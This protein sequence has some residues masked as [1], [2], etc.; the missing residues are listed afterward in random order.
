[1]QG[2]KHVLAPHDPGPGRFSLPQS[3]IISVSAPVIQASVVLGRE[4]C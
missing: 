4:Q 3:S 1:M 2:R